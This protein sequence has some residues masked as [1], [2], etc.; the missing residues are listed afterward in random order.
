MHC[1]CLGYVEV[2]HVTQRITQWCDGNKSRNM[3][4]T[5]KM[6]VTGDTAVTIITGFPRAIAT[7]A[8]IAYKYECDSVKDLVYGDDFEDLSDAAIDPMYEGLD[9]SHS[10]EEEEEET[11]ENRNN[12]LNINYVPTLLLA[13]LW[14][15]TCKW[16]R[17]LAVLFTYQFDSPSP[18]IIDDMIKMARDSTYVVYHMCDYLVCFVCVLPML[19]HNTVLCVMH[20]IIA[21]SLFMENCFNRHLYAQ[22]FCP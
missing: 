7:A 22:T 11:F 21:F 15:F 8:N 4:K 2:E 19:G 5:P 3:K 14:V 13:V 16:R 6:N 17:V 10:F 18:S 9:F 12:F 20:L 1:L